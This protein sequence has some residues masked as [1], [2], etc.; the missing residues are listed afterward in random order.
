M[1]RLAALLSIVLTCPFTIAAD[2][3]TWRA[4][5]QRSGYT[6][7]T[8]SENLTLNWTWVPQHKPLPA[9]PRDERMSFDRANH[10]V[11]AAG[12]VCFGS[13]SDSSVTAAGH[14]DR[15]RAAGI[16]SPAVRSASPQRSGRIDCS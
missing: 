8:L 13:S 1:K 4:D 3:T 5:S 11:V 10:V 15:K 6:S 14:R 16:S 9:W 2:W 12:L 7:D